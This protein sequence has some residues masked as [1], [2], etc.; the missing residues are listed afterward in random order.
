MRVKG[1]ILAL[2]LGAVL[3]SGCDFLRKVAGRPTSAEIAVV[4]EKVAE[5]EAARAKAV[6]DSIAAVE[7]SRAG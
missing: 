6:A 7:A 1:I 2:A 4:R 3:L 5:K